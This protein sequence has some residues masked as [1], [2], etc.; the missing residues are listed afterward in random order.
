MTI[1]DGP[2]SECTFSND[3]DKNLEYLN[4]AFGSKLSADEMASAYCQAGYD[5]QKTCGI[6]YSM[7]GSTSNNNIHAPT[8]DMT[9]APVSLVGVSR[10][11]VSQPK[12]KNS[13][14]SVGTV[15][16][17]I[18]AGYGKFR[19][20]RNKAREIT[21]PLKLSSS[22][23]PASQIWDES[24]QPVNA[25][26]ETMNRDI[27]Q[28]LLKMLGDGFQLDMEDIK[29]V[30]GGCGYDVQE[31]M[32]KL[33]EISTPTLDLGDGTPNTVH[34]TTYQDLDTQFEQLMV[35]N[36]CSG[37]NQP[38]VE[39]EILSSLFTL[40]ER[41][42]LGPKTIIPKRQPRIR[43]YGLVTGPFKEPIATFKTPIVKNEVNGDGNDENDDNFDTLRQATLEHWGTMKEYF[44]AAA[45]AYVEGSY[46]KADKLIKAG[47][48]YTEKAKEANLASGR[49]LTQ[50]KNDGE[51]IS[52]NVNEQEP[53]QAVRLLKTELTLMSGIP[54][55]QFLK[56]MLGGE[57]KFKK[58]RKRRI[59]RLLQKD[60]I[61][62]T[63]EQDGQI[64][65]I[66]I[67]VINPKNLS[68]NKS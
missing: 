63:E 11:T 16:G 4:G 58:P 20:S 9:N 61:A 40:P 56:V 30:V 2:S 19:A 45:K 5:M 49:M 39:K 54:S 57:D 24:P 60:S 42:E 22:E 28:F 12:P 62:W 23:I 31:S 37:S 68:F 26:T 8:N 1:K 66:R 67:D 35:V 27:E 15:S 48:L 33:M 43:K 47:Q 55:F 41:A 25:R 36:D 18:G 51:S 3:H 29:E 32:E 44:R 14:A 46:E 7:L 6:L 34:Q 52:I 53:D 21:K 17:V 13:G 59:I 50:P 64:M 65:V 10:G 38:K